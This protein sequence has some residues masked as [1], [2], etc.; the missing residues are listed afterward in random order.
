MFHTFGLPLYQSNRMLCVVSK[1]KKKRILVPTINNLIVRGTQEKTAGL[2]SYL[3]EDW[4]LAN[5]KKPNIALSI[6]N[7][8]NLV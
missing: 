8:P 7:M 1:K 6:P 3:H 5:K 4:T 2:Y